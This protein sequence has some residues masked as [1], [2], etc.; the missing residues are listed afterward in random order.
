MLDRQ[1]I[2]SRNSQANALDILRR[3][4]KTEIT[5]C[6]T[7]GGATIAHKTGYIGFDAG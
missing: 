3:S 2:L 1:S 7:L 6:W 5:C 4:F